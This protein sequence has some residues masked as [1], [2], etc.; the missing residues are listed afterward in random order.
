MNDILT[1]FAHYR[2]SFGLNQHLPVS[3]SQNGILF[4]MEYLICLLESSVSDEVKKQEIERLRL[5]FQS[6]EVEPGML[7]RFPGSGEYDSMDNN[8]AALVF[9]G[10][11]GERKFA[12]NMD[13]LG[14]TVKCDGLDQ[15]SDKKW[16]VLAT[17]VSIL[18][19][20]G[21]KPK[22][23]WNCQRPSKFCFKGWFGRS[24]GFMALLR[25]VRYGFALPLKL[26]FILIGQFLT[27]LRNPKETSDKKLAYVTWYYLTKKTPF[28]ERWAWKLAYKN[29]VKR[30]LKT[31]PNGMRDVYAI[32]YTDPKHPLHT[33]SPS[34]FKV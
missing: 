32:Y 24:P 19:L 3:T 17:V 1:D 16:Y 20:Y 6:C 26:L 21:I 34:H 4:T 12:K 29:W 15:E 27:L 13:K 23:Y 11:F 9:S 25:H 30:L 5:V 2:D 8:T 33:Y 28:W 18:T 7:I 31:Y 10:I 22:N 14:K